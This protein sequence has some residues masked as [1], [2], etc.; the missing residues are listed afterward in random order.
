MYKLVIILRPW[1]D[2]VLSYLARQSCFFPEQR[3]HCMKEAM[4]S[5][6]SVSCSSCR[7]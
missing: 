3:S 2:K 4:F 6:F 1:P 5:V 7:E